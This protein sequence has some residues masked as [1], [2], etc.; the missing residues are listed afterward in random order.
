VTDVLYELDEREKTCRPLLLTRK[1]LVRAASSL[2][3]TYLDD[4]ALYK[5]GNG[6]MVNI[7]T[8]AF[9]NTDELFASRMFSPSVLSEPG[10]DHVCGSGPRSN[11]PLLVYKNAEITPSHEVKA[12][13]VSKRGG[14]LRIVWEK[15]A[16]RV[17]LRGQSVVLATGN[18]GL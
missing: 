1:A 18:L 12:K 6:Y 10:E 3:I 4:R 2:R 17:R 8:T 13:Q 15:E 9:S 5:L 16:G 11:G 7:F 14:E